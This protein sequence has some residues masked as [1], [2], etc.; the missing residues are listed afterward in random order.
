MEEVSRVPIGPADGAAD[1]AT[2]GP[3]PG[4]AAVR[5]ARRAVPL[6][7]RS[8]PRASTRRTV[9]LVDAEEQHIRRPGDLVSAVLALVFIALVLLLAVYG[10]AT[11]T[12]VAED[13]TDVVN[14]TL[15]QILLL[16]V[17][18][19]EG[20]VIFLVPVSVIVF[21]IVRRQWRTLIEAL[22]A[23]VVVALVAWGLNAALELFEPASALRVGLTRNPRGLPVTAFS[24]YVALIAALLTA[25]GRGPSSRLI[26]W[27][28][29][30]LFVVIVLAVLQ[31]DQT[32]AGAIITVLLGRLA[33]FLSRWIGGARS[34]R[35]AGLSLVRGLRRAGLDPDRVVRLDPPEGPVKAWL[36]SSDAPVG[37]NAQLQLEPEPL[38]G[39]G[40]HNSGSVPRVHATAPHDERL[41]HLSDLMRLLDADGSV[42]VEDPLPIPPD[43]EVL[44]AEARTR[45]HSAEYREYAVWQNGERSDVTVLDA[46]RQVVGLLATL[47]ETIRIRGINRRVTPTLRETAEHAILMSFA[48]ASAGVNVPEVRG[49]AEADDSILIVQPHL[50][51][52][53]TLVELDDVDDALLDTLWS[54]IR[55]AHD[56]G[57][58]HRSITASHVAVDA[59]GTMWIRGWDSGEIV[60]SELSRRFDLAQA[61]TMIALKV[62]VGRAMRSASRNLSPTQLASIAPL[63]QG[64]A[65]PHETRVAMARDKRILGDLRDELTKLIPEASAEPFPLRRFSLRTV[66]SVSL[67]LVAAVVVF[68]TFNLN[69]VVEGFRRAN[70]LWL[71]AAFGF[72][73]STYFGAALGLVSFTQEK[74]GLW[75][76]T[77]V[78]IASSIVSLVAP[79]GVG[80][81]AIDLRYL[82]KQ[83]VPTPMAVATVSLTMVSRFVV[84]VVLLV[85]VT[86][87]TGSAGTVTLPSVEVISGILLVVA[88]AGI[89]ATIPRIRTWVM[90]RVKPVVHQVWPRFVWL[91]GN[92]RRLLMGVLGNAV[93][94][95]GYIVAFGLTLGAFGH[96][97]P[98]ATLAI[99][100]LAANSAGSLVPSPA[101][102][103]PVEVALTSG[104]TLAGIPSTTALSVVIV[105]R[106]LTLWARVPLGWLALRSLQRSND[107]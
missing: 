79:A 16:P 95:A 35:A 92:P 13:V 32:I 48:A 42:I 8:A 33:G 53:R 69:D 37:H 21:G 46:D 103:G 86:V 66:L 107:L 7:A 1:S 11:A 90:A 65:L 98:V 71:L 51:S 6:S 27:S 57:I 50:P 41:T 88:L 44:L 5:D 68:G 23:G 19:L 93:M 9:Q 36:V 96:S 102:I 64:V 38:D 20:L 99:T 4:P 28:W 63:L 30:F 82:T 75:R 17:T 24:P 73:L 31:G 22:V 104:L 39:S 62:G 78:Q 101:G 56:R 59:T 10:Q 60:S 40:R 52:P 26:R 84:T 12:G 55:S 76:T 43:V 45:P 70:P 72:G 25:A 49:I 54:Q 94:S 85:L 34:T 87:F 47:W 105:F 18:A 77:L 14:R 61:L 3:G 106:V 80:P 100:Y 89:L 81:A 58:S 2:A 97:L 29:N 83:R 74:L 67:L 15:R 91:L